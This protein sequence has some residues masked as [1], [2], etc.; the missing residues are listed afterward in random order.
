M[1]RVQSDVKL[2]HAELLTAV[3]AQDPAKA[4]MSNKTQCNHAL[5]MLYTKCPSTSQRNCLEYQAQFINQSFHQL[6]LYMYFITQY[7]A[8]LPFALLTMPNRSKNSH[9]GISLYTTAS[10][11]RPPY[12]PRNCGH[13]REM[14]F[15]ER[16]KSVY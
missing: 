5:Y 3:L 15:G 2:R 10:L 9:F 4:V 6:I 14:A 1:N 13:I 12:L 11:I 16:E 7:V 8:E